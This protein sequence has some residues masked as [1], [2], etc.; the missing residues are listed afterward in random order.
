MNI[1]VKICGRW[2]VVSIRVDL[3]PLLSQL[4]APDSNGNGHR[5]MHDLCLRASGWWTRQTLS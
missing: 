4:A 2:E 3:N 1:V 5:P